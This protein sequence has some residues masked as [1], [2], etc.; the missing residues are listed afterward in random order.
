ME[1]TRNGKVESWLKLDTGP[2]PVICVLIQPDKIQLGHQMSCYF[3][4]ELR[5]SNKWVIWKHFEIKTQQ[6]I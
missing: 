4:L 1:G 5:I 6:P 3:R 2:H